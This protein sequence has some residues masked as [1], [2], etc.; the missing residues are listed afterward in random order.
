MLQIA[1]ADA[2]EQRTSA[3]DGRTVGYRKRQDGLA[4]IFLIGVRAT[5]AQAVL[6]RIRAGSAPV[7][8][9]DDRTVEQR[10][11]DAAVDLLLGRDVLG[12]GRC[13]GA[14]CGCL[15]GQPAPCGSE[16]AVLVPHA[17]AEGRSDEPATL[18]G[19]GPIERDVLQAL[20]LN[21]PRLRPVF[22]DG[23]GIPVG[24]G[25]AAQTRTPVRGDLASVRRALTE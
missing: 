18:V 8:G 20:L 7:T 4:D 10:R 6:Q 9:W 2:V 5:D 17:V 21:A 19:H 24:I 11:L 25:T 14:G 22:V 3:E 13:A 23:N 1:P 12:T 15:P 16:I